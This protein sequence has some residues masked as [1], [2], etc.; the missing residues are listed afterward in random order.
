MPIP[1][2]TPRLH[3]IVPT[4]LAR[5]TVQ[6]VIAGIQGAAASL[7]PVCFTVTPDPGA[8]SGDYSA[9]V[10]A[11]RLYGLVL[12]LC[13]WAQRG[14]G[15]QGQVF[16][17][18]MSVARAA[19]PWPVERQVGELVRWAGLDDLLGSS[20]DPGSDIGLLLVAARAR[21]DVMDGRDVTPRDAAA[22]ASLSALQVRRLIQNGSLKAKGSSDAGW[23]ISPAEA[24][25]WFGERGVPG[26]PSPAKA[27]SQSKPLRKA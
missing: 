17:L 1:R 3:E 26:F 18:L 9:A 6:R 23:R 4:E 14:E 10:Q 22:L 20:G 25:R 24:R 19:F 11:S 21:L 8:V 2:S 27:K 7:A 15:R 13:G 5:A 16:D 12:D